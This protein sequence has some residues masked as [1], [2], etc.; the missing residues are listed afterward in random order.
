MLRVCVEKQA[1]IQFGHDTF[2]RISAYNEL[3]LVVSLSCAQS[4]S[5]YYNRAENLNFQPTLTTNP[6]LY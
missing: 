5:R 2:R 1:V 6:V 4:C 3:D